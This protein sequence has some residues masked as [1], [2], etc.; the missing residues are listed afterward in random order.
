[1]FRVNFL[2][3]TCGNDINIQSQ[4]LTASS[5]DEQFELLQTLP[6]SDAAIITER[7]IFPLYY[8]TMDSNKA[9]CGDLNRP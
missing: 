1:L 9:A 2:N 3:W 7:V 5:H 8:D 6:L 4:V